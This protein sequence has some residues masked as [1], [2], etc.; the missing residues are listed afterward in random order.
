MFITQVFTRLSMAATGV[1]G[2]VVKGAWWW[3]WRG[4]CFSRGSTWGKSVFKGCIIAEFGGIVIRAHEHTHNSVF[5][6]S[7]LLITQEMRI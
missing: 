2:V 7:R 5:D 3:W 4:Y 6:A 1:V